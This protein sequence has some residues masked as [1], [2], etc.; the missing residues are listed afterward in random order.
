MFHAS[1]QQ[2]ICYAI[3][4]GSILLPFISSASLSGTVP[5]TV[6]FGGGISGG[7]TPYTYNWNLGDRDGTNASSQNVSHTYTAVGTGTYTETLT[8]TDSLSHSASTQ[9]FIVVSSLITP[10]PSG[11]EII[12]PSV[13]ITAQADASSYVVGP[14]IPITVSASD[15]VGANE[16]EFSGL[17]NFGSLGL[18][19]VG[20]GVGDRVVVFQAEQRSQL[21]PVEFFHTLG[22]IVRQNEV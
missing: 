20:R 15:N 6:S 22:H 19:E 2:S 5:F 8:M 14:N 7:S 18:S 9:Q 11:P 10:P 12:P 17:G 4:G 3:I 21:F 13:A 16:T 1:F